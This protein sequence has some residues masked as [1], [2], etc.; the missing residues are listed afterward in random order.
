MWLLAPS[1]GVNQ[2]SSKPDSATTLSIAQ[3]KAINSLA[4][5]NIMTKARQ[6][7]RKFLD[8]TYVFEEL[9]RKYKSLQKIIHSNFIVQVFKVST[10]IVALFSQL[11]N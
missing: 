4:D 9:H 1:A 6:Y 3:I 5:M 2:L 8:N 11:G 7:N 10:I